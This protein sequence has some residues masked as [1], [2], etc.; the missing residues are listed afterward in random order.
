MAEGRKRTPADEKSWQSRGV[1]LL[2]IDPQAALADYEEALK[3]NPKSKDALM[4]KALVLGEQLKRP[5]DAVKVM[6]ELL[7]LYPMYTDA[8]ANRGVILARIGEAKRAREDVSAVLRDE[9]TPYRLFQMAGVYAQLSKAD[10]TA[11]SKQ[12]ALKLL[13]QAFRSG[14]S[15]FDKL[16]DK[17][18]DP[19]RDDPTFQSM[20]DHARQLRTQ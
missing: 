16:T 20:V 17:D 11:A 10:R 13:A 7:K 3:L 19:I 5:A 15:Q 8:R 2:P 14:F 12:E 4:C 6:D 18:L 1:S 9:P